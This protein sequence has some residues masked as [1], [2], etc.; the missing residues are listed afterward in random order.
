MISRETSDFSKEISDFIIIKQNKYIIII[1]LDNFTK[2]S[3]EISVFSRK[4]PFFE[5]NFL[6][7]KE[8]FIFIKYK[9]YFIK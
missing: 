7:S 3:K 8:I 1:T 4:I 5:I 2:C 9:L 6:V